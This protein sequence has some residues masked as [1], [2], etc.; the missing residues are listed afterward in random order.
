MRVSFPVQLSSGYSV[1][2][3]RAEIDT[4]IEYS[5]VPST[6]FI[7]PV[8]TPAMA[9]PPDARGEALGAPG[10]GAAG[11]SSGGGAAGAGGGGLGKPPGGG[12]NCASALDAAHN[13][14][15]A[16]AQRRIDRPITHP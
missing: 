4:L 8:Q 14:T 2:R 11:A 5:V 16:I 6:C 10:A 3:L 13:A 15:R 7:G 12:G 9:G 1:S